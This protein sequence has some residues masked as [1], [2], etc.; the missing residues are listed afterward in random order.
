MKK[1][2]IIL[3]LQLTPHDLK[4]AVG[5]KFIFFFNSGNQTQDFAHTWQAS[6]ITQDS[7]SL[8]K[9]GNQKKQAGPVSQLLVAILALPW[10]DSVWETTCCSY[11]SWFHLWQLLCVLFF[12][13]DLLEPHSHLWPMAASCRCTAVILPGK[14]PRTLESTVMLWTESEILL[15]PLGDLHLSKVSWKGL[16]CSSSGRKVVYFLTALVC[17]KV[18]PPQCDTGSYISFLSLYI[19]SWTRLC[20][21][22]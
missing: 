21:A 8:C 1:K 18:L 20:P 12:P 13:R 11:S 14:S 3:F 15:M 2:K 17:L 16:N 10:S 9:F 19:P 4:S 7:Q 5:F 22:V 6:Y